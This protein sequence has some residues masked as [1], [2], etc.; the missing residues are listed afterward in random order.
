MSTPGQS[1]HLGRGP[2]TSG[3]HS[4]YVAAPQELTLCAMCGR[5]RIGKDFLH[6]ASLVGAAMC[7]A[8]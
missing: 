4:G 3:L 7:P 1:R 2:V 6:V 5:L 8:F